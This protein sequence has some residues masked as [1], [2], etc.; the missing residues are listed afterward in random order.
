MDFSG[1]GAGAGPRTRGRGT[2]RHQG[3]EYK[4]SPEEKHLQ[5]KESQLP[6]KYITIHT[7]L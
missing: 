4:H 1:L 6:D 5:A 3:K 7:K 2:R